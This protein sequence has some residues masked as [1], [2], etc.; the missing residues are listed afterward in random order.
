MNK[1]NIFKVVIP[2]LILGA[3]IMYISQSLLKQNITLD[4]ENIL[5]YTG[6]DSQVKLLE[7]DGAKKWV[8]DDPVI[9]TVENGIIKA[10]MPGKTKIKCITEDGKKYSCNVEVKRAVSGIY[11]DIAKK[12]TAWISNLQL[13][14]GAFSCYELEEGLAA[15]VN[16]YFGCYSA[17]AMLMSD[18]TDENKDDVETFIN[19]YF[20]HMNMEPDVN[21]SV[22]TVYD[23]SVNISGKEVVSEESREKYDSADS[24]SA[25]FLILLNKYRNKYGDDN[26]L[27]NEKTKVDCVVD[28]L[29]SLL[30]DGYTQS[31]N[32]SKV[33]YLMNNAE[34]YDGMNN[35]LKIYE[36]LWPHDGRT[37]ML[38][39]AVNKFSMDFDYAWWSGT[40]YY[41]VLNK[42]NSSYYG[43]KMCWDKLYEYAVP[44]LFPV[45]F[46]VKK[47]DNRHSQKVYMDFCDN[48]KWEN[49][50]YGNEQGANQTWSLIV[51][52]AA[53]MED[54]DRVAMY[55]KNFNE[56]ISDRSYPYYSGDSVWL[57]LACDKAYDYFVNIEKNGKKSKFSNID[58]LTENVEQ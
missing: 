15:R 3:G 18:Y 37:K 1:K 36:S 52:A 9:A 45:I 50:D 10:G 49:F 31:M 53:V 57:A 29:L 32:G 42:D 13:S 7:Y 58:F 47:A 27:L 17:I 39:E 5:I 43:D 2:A 28:I 11:K 4:K 26:I 38:R 16:P 35:A 24:Y 33:K 41:P 34:T 56:K 54:Y 19:W 48:W 6:Y 30:H 20:T 46:D 8:T 44:Q 21:G 23:Y 55:I 51:Y 22:G 14:N 40:Y 25:M 12:E